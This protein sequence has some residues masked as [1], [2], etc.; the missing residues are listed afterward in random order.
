MIKNLLGKEFL[1]FDG[2]MGTML[3][4]R[5]LGIGEMPELYN[6]ENREVI[7]E[8]HK[9]Y[10]E[11]GADIISANTFGANDLKIKNT[12]YTVE[13]IIKA[14]VEIAREAA[15]EKYVA[16]DIGS[17]G[18]L[19]QPYGELSF[20][21]AY[22]LFKTQIIA[23][24]EAGCDLILIETMTD[25]YE[26]KAAILA[27]KENSDLPVFCTMTFEENGRT[28]TGTD[29]LTMVVILESLGVDAIGINC[30]LGPKEIAPFVKTILEYASVPV[31][32]QPNAG[33]PKIV[34]N[35]ASYDVMPEEFALEMKKVAEMGVAILG[36]C[37]GTNENYI[38]ELKK[39]LKE[40][41]YK[42]T[43]PKN[44]TAVSSNSKTVILDE[45]IKLIGERINPTGKKRF[46]EALRNKDIGYIL[47]EAMAQR[48][49]G[50]DILDVNVGLPEI[51]EKAT[52]IECIKEISVVVNNPL[53]ID[54]SDKNV[55]EAAVRIYNGKPII[56]SVN[57]KDEVMEEIFPIVK[58]YGT[59]VI[60]L[61]LDERGIPET[62]EERV[63]IAEKIINKAKEYGIERKNIIIDC[64]VLT[65]SA[66][67]N[68]VME[69]LKAIRLIKEKFNVKTTLGV[70]NIS[71]GLPERELLNKTFLTMAFTMGLDAPIINPKSE[72]IMSTIKAYKVL[73]NEDKDSKDYILYASK[74]NEEKNE[75]IIKEVVKPKHSLK[76]IVIKGLKEE[77]FKATK[78]LLIT[79]NSMDIINKQLIPALDHVG[80]EFDKGTLF[81]PSLI[82][83]AETVKVAFNIIKEELEA[84]GE[85][86]VNKGKVVLATVKGD[87]HDIG[88]NIVKVLLE[89]YGFEVI[90]LGKDV[91]PQKIVDAIK[92]HSIKLVGLSALM[93]TTVVSMQKTIKL[94]RENNL[95][96]KVL[97][98][99]AVLNQE[100]ADMIGADYYAKDARETVKI[101]QQLL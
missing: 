50:A 46:K 44:F 8:I 75:N 85:E 98:G 31:M 51:D 42:K 94:I 25:I 81:L 43:N 65:A 59:A 6:I 91:P 83:S 58:K 97:V 89:N 55:I 33:L 1:V 69:T 72:E 92:E 39:V 13:E 80:E 49:M 96:C 30:S 67:Q 14:G 82:Q 73:N 38:L 28:L 99:G 93:T 100:Y 26:A 7:L 35:I 57:G 12:K 61:T 16:L 34:E 10:I 52:M 86:K 23:G 36:G 78:E 17:T 37:C 56:N 53:Q 101:A 64:L 40:V 18:K 9:K 29:P 77:A 54:S 87:I 76:E 2:A 24:K 62:A 45:G 22:D 84:K 88:K 3:Q 68:Q 48:D 66:Q 15:G 90:D 79:E 63:E 41:K 71:F 95:P 21:D 70:S 60:G 20:E 27:A 47:D 11:A 74:K 32:V 4:S 5:G 19:L